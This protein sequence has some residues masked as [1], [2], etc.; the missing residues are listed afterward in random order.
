VSCR[1]QV[2][3]VCVDNP[4]RKLR[5]QLGS[6][7]PNMQS[8]SLDSLHLPIV[9][10]YATWRKRTPASSFLRRVMCKF[11][12]RDFELSANAWGNIYHGDGAID[13]D[14][15]EK[16]LREKIL[17]GSLNPARAREVR[18]QLNIEKPF[19]TRVEFIEALAALSSLFPEDVQRRVTGS[20]KQL[21]KVLWCAASPDRVE[22][23]L[24]N[25][26][27]RCLVD[28]ARLSLLSSGTTS[29]EA[30]HSEINNWFRQA[31]QMHRSTLA[32][33]LQILSLGKL[34]SHNSALYRPTTRQIRSNLVLARALSK[35]VWSTADW[36]KWCRQLVTPQGRNR[37]A[38]LPLQQQRNTE[39]TAVREWVAKRPAS[40][41]NL[42]RPATNVI[43]SLKRP[44]AGTHQSSSTKSQK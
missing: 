33:K 24:N 35:E 5:L 1:P 26:R 3:H 7:F 11:Q 25:I 40:S 12:R 21:S 13:L 22:W 18:D 8:L 16:S 23:L 32:L 2:K 42:R 30:L 14:R 10:E 28:P 37:K 9:F 6:V 15:Q 43:P 19:Y 31:Q 29:N 27:V 17:D 39:V 38:A 20:N 4:S 44:A 34:I 36:R 41:L